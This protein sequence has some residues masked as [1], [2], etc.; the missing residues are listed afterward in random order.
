MEMHH[1]VHSHSQMQR[2]KRQAS[3]KSSNMRRLQS[4]A[5]G[6]GGS[7]VTEAGLGR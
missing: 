6:A 7:D 5:Q 1:G 2:A 3:C 4:H